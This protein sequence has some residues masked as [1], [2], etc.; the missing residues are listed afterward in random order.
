MEQRPKWRLSPPWPTAQELARG[1]THSLVKG[2]HGIL[3]SIHVHDYKLIWTLLNESSLLPD[4]FV[5]NVTTA[6]CEYLVIIQINILFR[7]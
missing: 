3:L 1:A 5:F 4:W 7:L 6:S 2:M